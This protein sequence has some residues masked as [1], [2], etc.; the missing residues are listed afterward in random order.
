MVHH[1][2]EVANGQIVCGRDPGQQRPDQL[3]RQLQEPDR[4]EGYSG[5]HS[6]KPQRN[7]DRD[8]PKLGRQRKCCIS[9]ADRCSSASEGFLVGIGCCWCGWNRT[10]L[11]R[12]WHFEVEHEYHYSRSNSAQWSSVL[13]REALFLWC[14]VDGPPFRMSAL[15]VHRGSVCAYASACISNLNNH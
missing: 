8:K 12:C 11:S 2:K 4:H 6:R 5:R 3:R 7:G 10:T 14:K 1:R 9:D 15:G 13:G